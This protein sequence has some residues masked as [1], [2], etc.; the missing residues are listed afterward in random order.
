[1]P[2]LGDAPIEPEFIVLMN[3]LADLLQ[4]V[5]NGKG[6]RM[7]DSKVGFVL[8]VFNMNEVG[9]RCNYISNANR[10]DVMTLMK[11]QITYFE[12]MPSQKGNA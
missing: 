2:E 11:E 5:L 7:T 3:S 6:T 1:M 4:E 8:M 9:G 12:G 10:K